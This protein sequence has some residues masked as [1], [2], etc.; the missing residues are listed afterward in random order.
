M[1]NPKFENRFKEDLMRA[2]REFLSRFGTIKYF[3][4][5]NGSEYAVILQGWATKRSLYDKIATV[6][7]EKYTVI[8]PALQGFGESDE[9]KEPMSVSDYAEAI[10]ELLAHLGIKKAHFFCHSFGGRVLF[11]LNAMD[12]R[13]TEPDRLILCDVA[14]IVP[15]KPF[16]VKVKVRIFKI[17]KHFCPPLAAKM[18]KKVGSA[19][20][21]SA[22]DVMR[23]TLVLAVNE[24]LRHLFGKIEAPT[25]ITWGRF[26]DAVPL[27]DAYLIESSV[28]DSAV[29][30]FEQS[31]H[32]PFLTE[33]ARFI[34]ILKSFFNI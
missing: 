13:F 23:K 29:I 5:G 27:S 32:F 17:M 11:K 16:S 7:A 34:P 30:V 2:D 33:E 12:D 24:D 26:D 14:G 4:E 1:P 28:S 31:S 3:T 9:P 19:D 25:L 22:S 6:L 18:R 20:Y 21:N 10:N 15:K 8:F